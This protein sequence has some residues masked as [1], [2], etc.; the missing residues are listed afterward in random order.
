MKIFLLLF[1]I[2]IYTVGVFT[3]DLRMI[4]EGWL[5]VIMALLVGIENKIDKLK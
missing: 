2:A 3:N 4:I 1:G 5:M